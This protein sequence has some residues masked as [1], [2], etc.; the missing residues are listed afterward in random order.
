[1]EQDIFAERKRRQS[2]FQMPA[3]HY[4][5][6]YELYYLISGKCRIFLNHTLYH[7]EAGDMVLIAPLAIHH[8]TYGIAHESDRIVLSFS[9]GYLEGLKEACGEGLEETLFSSRKLSVEQGRRGYVEHL[10]QKILIEQENRD[11]YSGLLRRNYLTEL[12]AFIGRC[13]REP[14]QLPTEVTEAAIQE[15]AQYIYH[16]FAEPLTLVEVARRVHMTPTYFSR[17]FKKVTGFGYKEYI[18]HV[19]LKEA[20]R[21]LLETSVSVTEIALSCGFSDGNYFGDLFK[22]EKGISPRI[23]R[24]N[25]QIL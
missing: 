9:S 13:G 8:M 24:K 14:V 15:A 21:M 23:Y 7:L 19:R 11:E 20:S 3:E 16:H 17:K 25:P 2:D 12:L 10:M 5:H 6:D 1:M 22:K 18:T 4:H